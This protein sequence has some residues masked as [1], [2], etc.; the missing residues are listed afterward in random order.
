M[1]C[2]ITT[3]NGD[4]MIEIKAKNNTGRGK[5]EGYPDVYFV[6]VVDG[7]EYTCCAETEDVA[8]LLG[9][10]IKHEGMNSQ[11]AKNACRMLGINSAWAK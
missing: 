4:Q 2:Y 9:L 6:P 11:F 8:M 10:Q 1:P 7:K 5:I 3:Y